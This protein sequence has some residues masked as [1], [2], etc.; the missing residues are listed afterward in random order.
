MDL[1]C[2]VTV[3]KTKCLGT[4]FNHQ[5]NYY[6]WNETFFLAQQKNIGIIQNSKCTSKLY[7]VR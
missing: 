2:R 6:F 5:K 1:N 3:N 4:T 7:S